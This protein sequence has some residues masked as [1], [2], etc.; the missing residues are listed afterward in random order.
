L[1]NQTTWQDGVV[2]KEAMRELIGRFPSQ[3]EKPKNDCQ[4]QSLE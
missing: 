1:S 4:R 2:V 3:D